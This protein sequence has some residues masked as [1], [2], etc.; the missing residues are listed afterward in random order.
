MAILTKIPL[1]GS[2]GDYVP[3]LITGTAPSGTTLHTAATTLTAAGQGDEVILDFYCLATSVQTVRIQWGVTGTGQELAV[4]LQPGEF[5]IAAI[6][7][8]MIRN[9]LAV[10]AG[11]TT[12][13]G[14]LVHGYVIRAS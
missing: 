6:P 11:T 5:A 2:T 13:S 1:S 12:A 3:F 10:R 9:G 4:V 7:G 8:R 14:V